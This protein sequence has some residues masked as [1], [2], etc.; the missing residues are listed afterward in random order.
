MS[1]RKGASFAIEEYKR[2]SE[3]QETTS[4]SGALSRRNFLG[5]GSASL[6]TAALASL[7]VNERA[8]IAKGEQDHSAASKGLAG[9]SR[10][11]LN[12]VR[13]RFFRETASL[14]AGLLR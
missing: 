13:G 10:T 2:T 1:E 3:Q 11:R 8:N 7:T 5:V 12:G 6:A 9:W 4:G 14:I